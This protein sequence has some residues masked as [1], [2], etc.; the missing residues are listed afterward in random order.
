MHA[1]K[2][3]L[4]GASAELFRAQGYSGTAVKQIVEKA[5]A[6]FASLYHFFPGGKEQLGAETVRWSGAIYGR[7]LDVFFQGGD[8][9][10]ETEMFFAGAA[11]TVRASD[12]VE[13]CPIATVAL[14]VATNN[15]V[16]RVATADVFEL[17]ISAAADRFVAGGVEP[18]D[19]RPLAVS[20]ISL[21]EGAFVLARAM[22]DE[23]HLLAA[24][25]TASLAMSDAV[26]RGTKA[27]RAAKKSAAQAEKAV[28]P[29]KS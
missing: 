22:R 21:L 28:K 11:E 10:A 14:E 23:S 18:I 5:G 3:R 7:L 24:G 29:L 12:Y 1:T 9:V 6:P 13:G 4:V 19:A 17:W 2:E 8:L 27:H 16:L 25:E 20:I 26:K 15:E